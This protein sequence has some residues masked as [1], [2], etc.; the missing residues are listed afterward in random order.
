M[1]LNMKQIRI[2]KCPNKKKKV[3]FYSICFFYAER[4]IIIEA[5]A[6]HSELSAI[7]FNK[8]C[9][10]LTKLSKKRYKYIQFPTDL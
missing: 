4:K 1:K 10:G 8:V 6:L 7:Y 5:I 3:L 9:S 2:F